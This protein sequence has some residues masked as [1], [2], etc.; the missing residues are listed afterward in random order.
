MRELELEY[1]RRLGSGYPRQ[2]ERTIAWPDLF[3]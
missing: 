2:L 3:A 1:R